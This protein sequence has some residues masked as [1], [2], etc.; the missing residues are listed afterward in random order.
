MVDGWGIFYFYQIQTSNYAYFFSIFG[1]TRKTF[2]ACSVPKELLMVTVALS[3][4][5]L[6]LAS[7]TLLANPMCNAR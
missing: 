6:T 1:I 5:C 4:I 3:M 7:S 2:A